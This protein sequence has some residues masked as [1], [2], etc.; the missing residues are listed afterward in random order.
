M[1]IAGA[2]AQHEFLSSLRG[3]YQ[4]IRIATILLGERGVRR[5]FAEKCVP[6]HLPTLHEIDDEEAFS[7]EQDHTQRCAENN[8]QERA[9]KTS[10]YG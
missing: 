8:S 7:E 2:T 10:I 3:P 5:V 4:F 1:P 9:R 6:R